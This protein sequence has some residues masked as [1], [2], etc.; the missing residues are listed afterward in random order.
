AGPTRPVASVAV[1]ASLEPSSKKVEE[2]RL[3]FSHYKGDFPGRAT[4][5]ESCMSNK[6]VDE[7]SIMDACKVLSQEL[8][9]VSNYVASSW[10]RK[11]IQVRMFKDLVQQ[12]RD[13][14]VLRF[15]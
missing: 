10:Y 7:I 8:Q 15:R 4:R 1:F 14:V 3:A 5:T 6:C 12:C 13:A 2:I 11:R 9:P